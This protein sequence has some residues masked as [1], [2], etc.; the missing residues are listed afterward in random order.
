MRHLL[1]IAIILRL[2]APEM[3]YACSCELL[4]VQNALNRAEFVFVGKV[5]ELEL[6]PLEVSTGNQTLDWP[7]RHATFQVDRSWKGVNGGETVVITEEEYSSCSYFYE[8]QEEY[9]VFGHAGQL[10]SAEFDDIELETEYL[11]PDVCSRGGLLAWSAEVIDSLGT[12]IS[13]AV[14]PSVWGRIKALFL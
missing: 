8:P 13:S 14:E 9:L 4:S 5:I 11:V 3:T 12:P 7:L 6:E 1:S 2:V 10:F